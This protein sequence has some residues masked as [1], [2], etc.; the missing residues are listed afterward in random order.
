[1]DIVKELRLRRWAR[2]HYVPIAERAA[3]WDAVILDEMRIRD[4]DFASIIPADNP[5]ANIVPL[6]PTTHY[7]DTPHLGPLS[8]HFLTKPERQA[9]LAES[10][11]SCH[12]G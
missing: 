11:W 9:G 6:E 1:M 12:F 8:P 3:D 2:E 5:G 4:E 7:F 10:E